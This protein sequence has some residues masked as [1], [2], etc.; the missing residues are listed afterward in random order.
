MKTIRLLILA[1]FIVSTVSA[2][3]Y[4]KG[5]GAERYK[6][7]VYLVS[8]YEIDTV[9]QSCCAAQQAALKNRAAIAGAIQDYKETH[10]LGAQQVEKPQF[11]FATKNNKFSFAF[12]GYINLRAAYDFKGIADNIDFVPANIPM[13]PNYTTHQ[14]LMMEA[15]TTRLF[16]KAITNT[17][18][19]GHVVLFIEGDFRGGAQMSYTPRL[20]SAYISFLG[21]TL[22]RDVTTFCDLSAAPNTIDFQGPN[23][24]NFNF[25]T[26]IR[27]EVPFA[28]NH[29]K[30]GVAAEMP[31]VSGSYG[32]TFASIP[33]RVPDFPVYMQYSWG[34]N[35]QNHIRASGIFRNMYM[36]NLG[37][38]KNTSLFGWGVQA[39]GSMGLCRWVDL[40]FNGVYG[41]GITPYIQDISG[42]GLD[43]TPRP[44]DPARI[45][46]MPMYGWQVAGQINFIPG[47]LFVSG[48][49]S[50]VT[51]CK[52]EGFYANDEY[53]QGTYS[54]ANIFYFITPRCKVACEYLHGSR[55]NMDGNINYANRINTMIQYNF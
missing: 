32:T 52:K 47:K 53:K 18:A 38:G 34:R 9:Y 20:R 41:Q 16:V 1:L 46:T 13:T 24:Y 17:R 14:Q 44:T 48:G 29:L 2:Q 51:V 33:Q 35:R 25:A 39:S 37:T 54:F 30:F 55:K 31:E 42:L 21:L 4:K 7:T 10:R 49:Y 45:Q 5:K 23:A 12:G 26:M 50:S 28:D 22:G 27:Y 8:A 36:H 3:H 15:T 11:I 40:Y 43:F 6:P 19:L